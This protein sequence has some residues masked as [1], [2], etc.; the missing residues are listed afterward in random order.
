MDKKQQEDLKKALQLRDRVVR[1]LSED[2]HFRVVAV[3]NTLTAQTAQKNHNLDQTSA[4]FLSQAL[5]GATLMSAFLKGEERIILEFEGAGPI[6]KVYAEALQV[7]ETRG[8]V[9]LAPDAAERPVTSIGEAIGAGMLK[10]AKVLFD[11][12][13]PVTGIVP[14][15][16]GDIGSDLAHYFAQS[17]QIPTAV[18]LD[19]DF[20]ENGIVKQSGGLMV[21]AMPG[22]SKEQLKEIYESLLKIKTIAGL[23]ES[24]K[25]PL[26]VLRQVLPFDFNLISSSQVDFF[27]RCSKDSFKSKLITLGTKE[28]I[29][30]QKEGHDKLVCQYCNSEYKLDDEDFEQIIEESRAK[31]N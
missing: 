4:F 18:V 24:E 12:P 13:E 16:K 21:Q 31:R 8:Y 17:E 1:V 28:L 6:R 25:N 15:V 26:E 14:L 3:K 29:S 9:D 27:C 19:V 30:M 2:G 5:S 10:V 7:G 23:Y 20:D 11:E 22:H